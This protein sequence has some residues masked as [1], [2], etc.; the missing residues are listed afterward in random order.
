MWSYLFVQN[1]TK[2][3]ITASLRIS[4]INCMNNDYIK[5]WGYLN[6]NKG[7]SRKII[8]AH[9]KPAF[10]YYPLINYYS[11]ILIS[12][13]NQFFRLVSTFLHCIYAKYTF[14]RIIYLYKLKRCSKKECWY[15]K[16]KGMTKWP[17]QKTTYRTT[18]KHVEHQYATDIQK[19]DFF[20]IFL[21]FSFFIS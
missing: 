5:M 20:L 7:Y 1:T 8:N 9:T 4:Y 16:F 19:N 14:C 3:K 12:T 18:Q 21:F 10:Q 17:V 11:V 13:A 6:L 15:V 2:I